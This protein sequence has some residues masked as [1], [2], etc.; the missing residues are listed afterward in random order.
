MSA[1]DA[2]VLGHRGRLTGAA[3]GRLMYACM[4]VWC[5]VWCMSA[6]VD[7]VVLGHRGHL[8]GTAGGR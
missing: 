7:A 1:V 2:V 8:T 3:G 5:E 4:H 6:H